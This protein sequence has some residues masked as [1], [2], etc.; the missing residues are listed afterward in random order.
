M[1]YEY[2]TDADRLS[3]LATS[4]LGLDFIGIDTEFIRE[5]SYYPALCLLQIQAD[6][7][8]FVIDI[9]QVGKVAIMR[10]L[11]QA[12][13]VLKVIH[14]CGEDLDALFHHFH[15]LPKSIFDTQMAAALLDIGPQVGYGHLVEHYFGQSISKE[16]SRTDWMARPLTPE[17][18]NYA[19]D[20][21]RY[22]DGIY[23]NQIASLRE[24][25]VLP[26]FEEDCKN[27]VDA[28]RY[29]PIPELMY[30]KVK[31]AFTLSRK[32]LAVLR[33][34]AAWR[35]LKARQQNLPRGFIVKDAV[36]IE[37]AKLQPRNSK[38]LASVAALRA[39]DIRRYG[40]RLLACVSLAQKQSKEEWPGAI[41]RVTDIDNYKNKFN[42]LKTAATKV[43]QSSGVPLHYLANRKFIESYMMVDA[44]LAPLIKNDWQGWR[45]SLLVEPFQEALK[46]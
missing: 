23:Q 9:Q 3:Q 6:K 44:G 33:E 32:Q 25:N 37:I 26:F 8:L 18:L 1:D 24:K 40:E 35:E 5:R 46:D 10:D 38:A 31:H 29:H 11:L 45:Q 2:I 7:A 14:A 39:A 30:L 28:S 15:V 16:Y 21:V 42:A 17:Q 27:I 13:S 22:L 41:P 34:L 20:D 12:D 19:A 36:L 43:S 4:W